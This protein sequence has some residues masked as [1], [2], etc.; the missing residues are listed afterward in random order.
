MNVFQKLFVNLHTRPE[1][2]TIWRERLSCDWGKN[3]N[4]VYLIKDGQ[5]RECTGI[6][7]GLAIRIEGHDNCIEIDESCHFS[8]SDLWI[9]GNHNRI[10]FAEKA[11]L[12]YLSVRM[13]DDNRLFSWGARSSCEK[14]RCFVQVKDLIVG[15]DCMFS[16]LIEIM[17]NDGHSVLD[18]NTRHV[19]NNIPGQ[20][21]IGNHVWVGRKVFMMKNANIPDDCIVGACAL[22]TK[23]FTEPNCA[24][25]GFPAKVVKQGITWDGT[26]P[27]KYAKNQK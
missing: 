14:V 22:V 1:T 17:T 6:I 15:T 11:R 12:T 23:P 9:T 10:Q 25:A 20:M 24:I 21:T 27:A 18:K 8:K 5:R 13:P 3:N 26:P 4:H 7:K 2:R 19:L 16:D